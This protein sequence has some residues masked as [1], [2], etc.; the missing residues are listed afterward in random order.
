MFPEGYRNGTDLLR[1]T[2]DVAYIFGV[3]TN[4]DHRADDVDGSLEKPSAV[5]RGYRRACR[6]ASALRKLGEAGADRG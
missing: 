2:E 1:G 5:I 3:F 4:G 6:H